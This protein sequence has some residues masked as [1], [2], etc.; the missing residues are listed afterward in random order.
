LWNYIPLSGVDTMNVL[1]EV[2][3]KPFSNYR[4]R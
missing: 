4:Y 3:L 1:D 2:F